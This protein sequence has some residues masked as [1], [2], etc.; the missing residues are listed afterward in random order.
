V[1]RVWAEV[2]QEVCTTHIAHVQNDADL[3]ELCAETSSSGIIVFSTEYNAS[4]GR[5]AVRE[6]QWPPDYKLNSKSP[7]DTM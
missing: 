4:L 3:T 1:H 5:R 6:N 7:E 2:L